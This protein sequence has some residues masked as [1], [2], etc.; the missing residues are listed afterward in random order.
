M[1]R[2]LSF[3]LGGYGDA[4][5]PW[6]ARR[7]LVAAMLADQRPDLVA[8]QA[9]A[10]DPAIEAGDDQATQLARDVGGYVVAYRP[11][12]RDADGR[13]QGLAFLSK[14]PA[15][16]VRVRPLSR[17]GDDD[18]FDRVLLH[19]QFAWPRG[20]L[21]VVCA[22]LSWIEDQARDNVDELLAYLAALAGPKL[23]VGD[24]NQTPTS[25]ALARL[26]DAG[27]VDAWAALRPDAAGHTFYERG[28][29][30]KRIDYVLLD[31]GLA[32]RLC[33]VSRV[34]D[35]PGERRA[36]DHAGV[37]ARLAGGDERADVAESTDQGF[38]QSAPR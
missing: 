21:H 3:N 13:E 5:G 25:D 19:G 9:V 35:G 1:T 26:L 4:H 12:A 2:I 11:A 30:R 36:S 28:A 27:L 23:V 34:L 31:R 33:D 10:R 17:R 7:P 24:F 29:L 37:L 32:S 22:H 14:V 20:P 6:S 8:L 16:T 15:L 18:P 38:R